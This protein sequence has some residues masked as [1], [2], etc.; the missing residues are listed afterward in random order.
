MYP[1]T[2]PDCP[3][4]SQFGLKQTLSWI[5]GR[6]D[7]IN[8]IADDLVRQVP[9]GTLQWPSKES[10]KDGNGSNY[11]P[12]HNMK[13]HVDADL[14]ELSIARSEGD[15]NTDARAYTRRRSS[16]NT[17]S[18][19][20]ETPSVTRYALICPQYHDSA[21]IEGQISS[22]DRQTSQTAPGI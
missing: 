7:E 6:I 17:S 9:A 3:P 11:G 21:A 1:S 13:R 15:S 18:L 12:S 2:L 14:E 10:F 5:L 20:E 4:L 8:S 22:I 16:T 19:G